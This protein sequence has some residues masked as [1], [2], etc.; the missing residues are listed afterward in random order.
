MPD[1]PELSQTEEMLI[2]RV[3]VS[4]D[5]VEVCRVRGQQ[6]KYSGHIVN[7]LRDTGRVYDTLPLLPRNLEVIILR[8]A[9]TS[10]D[11]R[12]QRQFIRDFRVRRE[13]VVRWLQ[14]LRHNH[15]GYRDIEVSQATIDLLPPDSS[16]ADDILAEEIDPVE[17]RPEGE[18]DADAVSSAVPD[19][20]AREE[21]I[22]AIRNQLLPQ[23]EQQRH[24]DFPPFRSTPISEFRLFCLG[25][26]QLYFPV[27][28]QSL[29]FPGS[30]L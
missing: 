16:V 8:P 12:L 15:P 29:S 28:K 19:F 6:Y 26:F 21:E 23:Q 13:N 3:H 5:S 1:L 7:F 10:G 25:H 9:N 17:T 22:D 24:L 27:E 30:D 2:A 14:Y 20:L 18:D 4:V 11:P